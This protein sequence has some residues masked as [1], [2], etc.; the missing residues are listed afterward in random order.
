MTAFEWKNGD[1]V[2]F[3]QAEIQ[4]K[5]NEIKR[6]FLLHQ[7]HLPSLQILRYLHH[8]PIHLYPVRIHLHLDPL[9]RRKDLAPIQGSQEAPARFE[10]GWATR[11]D[12]QRSIRLR[13]RETEL[14]LDRLGR[15][16]RR[17]EQLPPAA[18]YHH[19][20]VSRPHR[21][22]RLLASPLQVLQYLLD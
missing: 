12:D 9:D 17:E 2:V 21:H 4:T 15:I 6:T 3:R 22:S 18:N 10:D 20:I 13:K 5:R 19:P 11:K 7:T 16:E 1:A 14:R 8:V